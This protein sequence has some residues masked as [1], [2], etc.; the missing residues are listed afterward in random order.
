MKKKNEILST[1][2][3]IRN[4]VYNGGTKYILKH[5]K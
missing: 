3:E 2:Q 5:K 1:K 4:N